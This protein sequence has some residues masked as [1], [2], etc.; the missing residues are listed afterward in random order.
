MV[1]TCK[2]SRSPVLRDTSAKPLYHLRLKNH[3]R[4]LQ[5]K[6]CKSHRIGELTMTLFLLGI[7]YASLINSNQP[8][9]P[10]VS[11]TRTTTGIPMW[12][13]KRLGVLNHKQRTIGYWGMLAVREVIFPR[14]KHSIWL[15]NN[16]LCFV[17]DSFIGLELVK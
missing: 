13:G 17:K 1:L 8:E 7:S 10:N 16:F 2:F 9:C 4:R 15:T 6:L 11:W 14:E 12:T 5:E 3:C